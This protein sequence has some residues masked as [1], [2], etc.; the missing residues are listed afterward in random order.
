MKICIASLMLSTF[1]LSAACSNLAPSVDPS[2]GGMPG[3]GSSTMARAGASARAGAGG[4]AGAEPGA[5]DAGE[6]GETGGVAGKA[7]GS[8]GNGGMGQAGSGVGGSPGGGT[9]GTPSGGT[10]GVVDSPAPKLSSVDAHVVGRQGDAVLFTVKGTQTAAGVRS[11]VVQFQDSSGVPLAMF[12]GNWDGVLEATEG[13]VVLDAPVSGAP[14]SATATL[15]GL[16]DTSKLAKA[17]V[18]LID[19]AGQVSDIVLTNVVAQPLLS[20]G[21]ACD[22]KN[23]LDRC[24]LGQSCSGTPSKCLAGVAPSLV[25]LKYLHD[26]PGGP[27]ILARG[28]DP[29]DDVSLLH[30]E[31]LNNSNMPVVLDPDPSTLDAKVNSSAFGAFFGLLKGGV[32]LETSVPRVRVTPIDSLGHQGLPLSANIADLARAAD[33]QSCDPRGF[34]GCLVDSVCVAGLTPSAGKCTKTKAA[35]ASECTLAIKLAPDAG[36]T[37]AAGKM[38]GVSIWDPPVGCVTEEKMHRPEGVV[39]LHLATAATTLTI[40][41]HRPETDVDTVLYLIPGCGDEASIDAC[42][43][44]DVVG[45]AS[46]LTLSNVAAGD[47]TI[48]VESAQIAGG[49]FGIA[50][51]K[52]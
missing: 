8:S 6:S 23:L 9:G 27:L 45:F 17:K 40:T 7:S 38:S 2:T 20:T 10:A 50:V 21:A 13:R 4:D 12:D 47:Y 15:S 22:S 35:R 33:G 1:G 11:I 41:T 16:K 43:D 32:P 34:S 42:N 46:G 37:S 36:I 48:I 51:S 28:T 14:L 29:D 18:S 3:A 52:Q 5:G 31:L 44:D 26:A 49:S 24:D 19:G 25:E 39:S 30:I